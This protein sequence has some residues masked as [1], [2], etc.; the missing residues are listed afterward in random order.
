M[1]RTTSTIHLHEVAVPIRP[2]QPVPRAESLWS[3]LGRAVHEVKT[4]GEHAIVAGGIVLASI[5]RA[6]G[7]DP[8]DEA[9]SP[10][11]LAPVVLHR[12]TE[13]TPL[14]SKPLVSP[15]PPL[16]VVPSVQ[17]SRREVEVLRLVAEGR[18]NREIGELLFISSNTAANHVRSILQKTGAANR[19]EAVAFAGRHRLLG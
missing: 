5:R 10:H 18:S 4:A 15:R 1:G 12:R 19:A 14:V 16:N 9:P 7:W 17:L 6:V 8:A 13:S 11:H 3:D 2:P